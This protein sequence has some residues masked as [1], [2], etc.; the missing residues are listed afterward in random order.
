MKST[1]ST[2]F[3]PS[4]Y[5]EGRGERL[6]FLKRA[7]RDFRTEDF[8]SE[9]TGNTLTVDFGRAPRNGKPE[10]Y[11]KAHSHPRVLF[12]AEDIAGVKAALE[13]YSDYPFVKRFKEFLDTEIDGVLGEMNLNNR[14]FH[15]WDGNLLANIQAHALAY[16]VWGDEYFGYSAIYAIKNYLLT[17]DVDYIKSDQ[18]REFGMVMYIAA[19]VYDWC[20]PLL[21]DEDKIQIPLGIEHRLCRGTVKNTR[22]GILSTSYPVKMEMGFPPRNQAALVGHGSEYQLQRDFLAIA[23]AV[24]DELPSWSEFVGGRFFN[25]YVRPRR[26]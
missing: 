9:E 11:P 8:G 7:V 17:L 18:C 2:A 3:S 25:E 10:T 26:I 12:C 15:N 19:C 22:K 1:S 14:G 4:V 6:D 20:Y 24:Y 21:S 23:I 16:A 5:S 13:A